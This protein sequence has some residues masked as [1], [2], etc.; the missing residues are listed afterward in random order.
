MS[1]SASQRSWLLRESTDWVSDGLISTEQA[2]RIVGRY[3]PAE[4][5][6]L[7]RTL[8]SVIGALLVGLGIILFFAFNWEAMHRFAKL[9][10]LFAA[11]LA[12]HG[13]GQWWLREGSAHRGLGEAMALLGSLLFGA[14]LWLISQIYHIDEHFPNAFIAWG[15]AALALAWVLPS[16]W[17]GLLAGVLLISWGLLEAWNFDDPQWL[18]P[19]LL[20]SLVALALRLRSVALLLLAVSGALLMLAVHWNWLLRAATVHFVYAAGVLCVALAALLQRLQAPHWARLRIGLSLPGFS[21]VLVM[22]FVLTFAARSWDSGVDQRWS[23]DLGPVLRWLPLLF[24]LPAVVLAV[25]PNPRLRTASPL[26]SAHLLLAAAG[27]LLY[28]MFVHPQ[29]PAELR[30]LS[31]LMNLFLLGH[32][33]LFILE[34]SR[35]QRGGLVSLGCLLVAALV[36]ARYLD[37]FESLLARS[38]AFLLLGIGLVLVGQFY[39]RQRRAGAGA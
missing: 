11:L 31:L 26:F 25:L 28:T 5:S 7:A 21:V 3:P 35:E 4:G 6:S 20:L 15:L 36:F 29:L 8:F 38:A 32:G 33:L 1:T 13:A 37:L 14:G 22:L 24:A 30:W 17:Q 19:L 2:A 23:A 18:A 16:M 10:L 27:L 34:G 9:G 39:A 12:A